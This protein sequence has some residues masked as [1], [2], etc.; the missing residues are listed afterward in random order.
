MN[1]DE[2]TQSLAEL[3]QIATKAQ[4][5]VGSEEPVLDAYLYVSRVRCGRRTC[6]CMQ[7]SYRHEKWCL[8]FTEDG[9]SRTLT[10][11]EAWL[12]R[13]ASATRAYR[14]TRTV[15]R[16]LGAGAQAVTRNA[17]RRL[18]RRVVAGRQLLAQV[19]AAKAES[20]AKGG[21]Q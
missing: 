18:A 14:D 10:V 20:A 5:E 9:R 1:Q 16:R 3:R 4:R 15:V 17:R 21:A 12:G 7:S 2:W 8:S 11:P 13:I 6:K 19:I